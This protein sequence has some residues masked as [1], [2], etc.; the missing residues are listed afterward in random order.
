MLVSAK[1][2]QVPL[3]EPVTLPSGMESIIEGSKPGM[4]VVLL[5]I[6]TVWIVPHSLL[7][8]LRRKGCE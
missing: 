1:K 8:L 2:V 4:L 5:L 3:E 6:L 7:S